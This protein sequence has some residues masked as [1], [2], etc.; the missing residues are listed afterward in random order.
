MNFQKIWNSFCLAVRFLTVI[1][2]GK[3]GKE[4]TDNRAFLISFPLV[5]FLIGLVLLI[6]AKIF[7]PLLPSIL[8][9]SLL[10]F[11][12]LFL[13]RML[14]LDGLIDTVDGLMGGKE[15]ADALRIMKEPQAGSF[16]IVAAVLYLITFWGA[17]SYFIGLGSLLSSAGLGS[18]LV[19]PCVGRWGMVFAATLSRPSQST[20]LGNWFCSL[21]SKENLLWASFI[22]I[23]V[24][25][26]VFKWAGLLLFFG[27]MGVA[28]GM[29]VWSERRIDGVTGDILGAVLELTQLFVFVLAAAFLHSSSKLPF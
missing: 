13:T 23:V 1:P 16:G 24:A 11:L 15:K 10:L 21:Q 12:Y 3:E 19:A 6:A 28:W 9:A 20:G 27:G 29:K 7:S 22:P 26:A 14:H 5:G 8:L 2:L 18:L 25:V 17:L 4:A